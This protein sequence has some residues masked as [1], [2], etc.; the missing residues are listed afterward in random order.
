[1]EIVEF[2]FTPQLLHSVATHLITCVIMWALVVSAIFIDL[3]DRV[4]TQKK[5]GRK[6]ISHRLRMTLDKVG[7]YWRF[8]LIAF[9]ID[10]IIFISCALLGRHMFPIVTMLFAGA[11]LVIE[12]KSLIEH[13]R[14]RHSSAED[15]EKIISSVVTAAS[16]RDAK[17]AIKA[18][19]DYVE[20]NQRKQEKQ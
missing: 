6:I 15:M 14:E 5:T 2:E 13:A 11:L 9:I 20:D 18:I 17:N 7:E 10:A 1:M 16:E 12:T 8:L 19:V 4:Y 3:W